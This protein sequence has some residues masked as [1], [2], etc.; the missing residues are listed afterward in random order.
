MLARGANKQTPSNPKRGPSLP[1]HASF[2]GGLRSY[3][4]NPVSRTPQRPGG[5]ERREAERMSVLSHFGRRFGKECIDCDL[6]FLEAAT[7]RYVSIS[8]CAWPWPPC[9]KKISARKL[10]FGGNK[11]RRRPAARNR[12]CHQ[13]MTGH[14]VEAHATS[15]RAAGSPKRQTRLPRNGEKSLESLAHSL[16]L[17]LSSN[18]AIKMGPNKLRWDDPTSRQ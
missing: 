3:V 15:S 12:H 13:W 6:S 10:P 4:H 17:Y 1:R 18:S 8:R 2:L 7:L 14:L 9:C 16:M 11:S 5:G